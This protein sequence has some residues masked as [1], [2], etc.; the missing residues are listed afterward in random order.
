MITL[1]EARRKSGLTISNVV[2]LGIAS[3]GYISDLENGIIKSPS[4]KKIMSLCKMYG[5]SV[6]DIDV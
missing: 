1:K 4:F 3:K 5:V 6:Y 2:D